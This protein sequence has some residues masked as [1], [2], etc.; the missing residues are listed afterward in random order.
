MQDWDG[1]C[2]SS[3]FHV[4]SGSRVTQA[5]KRHSALQTAIT[6]ACSLTS[7][8]QDLRD[9]FIQRKRGWETLLAPLLVSAFLSPY[10]SSPFLHSVEWDESCVR[11]SAD[12]L[13]DAIKIP[14]SCSTCKGWAIEP[15]QLEGYNPRAFGFFFLLIVD[16]RDSKL[17]SHLSL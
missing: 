17:R 1:S 10:V 9:M 4:F 8:S 5:D 6:S 15:L 13:I 14:H 16:Y 12:F 11:P 7:L 2:P 3:L